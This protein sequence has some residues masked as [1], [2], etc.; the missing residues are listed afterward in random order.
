MHPNQ[1]KP[2]STRQKVNVK[3]NAHTKK[4]SMIAVCADKKR[5]KTNEKSLEGK[6]HLENSSPSVS[7]SH[8]VPHYCLVP[9]WLS[10]QANIAPH[11]HVRPP[12]PPPTVSAHVHAIDA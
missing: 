7:F 5:K 8:S 3:I 10:L 11:H 1:T 12:Q 6:S 4:Q 2:N 9:P